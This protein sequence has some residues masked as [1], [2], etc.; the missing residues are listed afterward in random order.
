[1]T[2]DCT[3]L[4]DDTNV[5]KLKVERPWFSKDEGLISLNHDTGRILPSESQVHVIDSI[6]ADYDSAEESTLVFSTPIPPLEK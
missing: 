1:M 6:V 3:S 5:S 2:I 4:A